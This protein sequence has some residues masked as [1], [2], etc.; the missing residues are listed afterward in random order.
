MLYSDKL[1]LRRVP[2]DEE[3]LGPVV[4][5]FGLKVTSLMLERSV[6]RDSVEQEV[7]GPSK[8]LCCCLRSAPG[9][10]AWRSKCFCEDFVLARDHA[11]NGGRT[12]QIALKVSINWQEL[13]AIQLEA[14]NRSTHAVSF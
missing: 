2:D 11:I 9:E 4:D 13:I 1:S 5:N 8:L 10:R 3:N 12:I 7:I 14:G 6:C